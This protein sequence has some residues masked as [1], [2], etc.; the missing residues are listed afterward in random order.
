M[1]R[2]L[3]LFVVLFAACITMAHSENKI[4]IT[5]DGRSISATL[6]DNA[7]TKALVE[8]LASGA[9]TISMNNYGGF[10]KVGALPW[11]LPTS[12][13]RITTKPGDI[14]LYTGNNIVIFYGENTWEYTPLGVLDTSDSA[15]I[16]AFVGSGS[17]QVVISLA[18]NSGI[19][20]ITIDPDTPEKVFSLSGYPVY[21]RP[22]NP[23]VYIV[24][25]KKVIVK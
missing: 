18:D 17:K 10:E 23:G 24:D 6:A 21:N 1:I 2:K 9:V 16:S 3:T 11:S 12:D 20:E 19:A 25:K 13:S 15:L 8:K 4:S 22:L 7:A 14:M 5:I